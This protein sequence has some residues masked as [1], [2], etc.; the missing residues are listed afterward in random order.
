MT[1]MST[2][3]T[4]TGQWPAALPLDDLWEGDMAGVT[5]AGKEILLV[6]VDGEVRAY[7]NRCPHQAWKL[8]DGDLDGCQLTCVRHMWEFEVLTGHGINPEDARLKPHQC[9]VDGDGIIRVDV[10]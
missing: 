3:H 7:E 8:S 10:R 1:A 5:V 9:E 4:G 6:N 2:E